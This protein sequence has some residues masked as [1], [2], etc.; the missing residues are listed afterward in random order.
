MTAIVPIGEFARL[1]HLSVKALHHYHDI[2]LLIPAEID[3]GT[4]YRRY[5]TEQVADAHLIRR[6]RELDMPLPEIRSVL[7]A[8]DV[9]DRDAALRA[10]LLRMEEQLQRTQRV[11]ASLRGLLTPA[12]PL[13]V[14]YRRIPAFTALTRTAVVPQQ[15]IEAWCAETFPMLY[16]AVSAAGIAPAGVAGAAYSP[17]FF[18]ADVGEVTGFVPISADATAEFPGALTLTELPARDFAITT[19]D[20]PYSDIDRAYG[21]LGSHV[22][23]HDLALPEPIRELYLISPDEVGDP[24]GYRTELCWPISSAAE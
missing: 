1:S 23:E 8:D 12:A 19:H 11:V 22:A 24:A 14:D 16:Q 17:E 9:A 10:H 5:S 21:A 7:A 3:A 18:T 4:G 6:L 13:R 2:D 15:E 20:G